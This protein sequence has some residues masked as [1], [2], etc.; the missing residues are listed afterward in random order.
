MADWIVQAGWAVTPNENRHNTAECVVLL[1]HELR[2]Q[3]LEF[4]AI[5]IVG[6][7]F[8]VA[9]PSHW[10]SNRVGMFSSQHGRG[11]KITIFG[12]PDQKTL[13]ARG[14]CANTIVRS[15]ALPRGMLLCEPRR[16]SLW[17]AKLARSSSRGDSEMDRLRMAKVSFSSLGRHASEDQIRGRLLPIRKR[18]R[19]LGR[20]SP[21]QPP[22]LVPAE[23]IIGSQ[24]TLATDPT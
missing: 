24:L 4:S 17:L 23:R 10:G 3:K 11:K 21:A 9:Q 18:A 5:L 7:N 15:L 6:W 13:F 22:P 1:P 20:Q 2:A 19:A 14:Y 8:C 12:P 16:K